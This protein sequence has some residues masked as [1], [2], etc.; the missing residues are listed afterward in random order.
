MITTFLSVL[1]LSSGVSFAGYDT[2]ARTEA[3]LGETTASFRALYDAEVED[4][5]QAQPDKV[6]RDRARAK[7]AT[8]M[9]RK[10]LVCSAEDQFYAAWVMRHSTDVDVL[11]AAFDLAVASMKGHVPR[12]NWLT[13]V[14]FDRLQ[15]YSG[16]PQRYGSMIGRDK[17]AMCLY[18]IDPAVTDADR[19]QYGMPPIN[20]Q[21]SK[22][23]LASKITEPPTLREVKR[24]GLIC[25][26]IEL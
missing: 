18:D 21:F 3:S 14:I 13:A 22:V 19:T 26:G 20:D 25:P 24:R 16:F 23:L 2:C 15:V 8:K 10:G 12:S 1:L 6:S 9:N 11:Q 7:E 5:T 4:A 17:G